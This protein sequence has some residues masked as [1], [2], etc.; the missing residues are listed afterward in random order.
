MGD[1]EAD[2]VGARLDPE[3]LQQLRAVDLDRPDAEEEALADLTVGVAEGQ[4]P[5]QGS[6][7]LAQGLQRILLELRQCPSQ[8]GIYI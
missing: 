7:A 3:L 1:R 8:L 5:Q 6:L 2:Q 4:Q